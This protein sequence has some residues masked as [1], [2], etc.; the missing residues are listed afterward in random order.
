MMSLILSFRSVTQFKRSHNIPALYAIVKNTH[1]YTVSDNLNML[2]QMLP[3]R[4]SYDISVKASSDYHL[5]EKEEPVEVKM[6]T[7]L[8]D[9]RKH[10]EHSQYTLVCN[11]YDLSH[12]FYL[13]KQAG[14]EPQARFSAGF[15]SELN[16]KFK[17]QR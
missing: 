12:L 15:V 2:R 17:N 13:S 1:I 7:S 11:G 14:Y 5:N 10:T 16:C 8:G 9:I 6:I 4:S 3:N